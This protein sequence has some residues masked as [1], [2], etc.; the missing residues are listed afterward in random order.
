MGNED[1]CKCC[2]TCEKGVIST[3]TREELEKAKAENDGQIPKELQ[4][5]GDCQDCYSCEVCVAVQQPCGNCYSCQKCDTSED[6]INCQNCF[7][8]EKCFSAQN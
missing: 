4:I 6:E 2:Y 3:V 7:S 5:N 8:C 1:I